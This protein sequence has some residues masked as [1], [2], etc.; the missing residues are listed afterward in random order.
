M[1]QAIHA[2]CM[3]LQ[4]GHRPLAFCKSSSPT[5]EYQENICENMIYQQ[6]STINHQTST[7]FS[8]FRYFWPLTI[9]PTDVIGCLF[10]GPLGSHRRVAVLDALPHDDWGRSHWLG[11]LCL[12]L[13]ETLGRV[14]H[15]KR[16]QNV[17][18]A[19]MLMFKI[20]LWHLWCLN[21]LKWLLEYLWNMNMS[22]DIPTNML[23]WE[24]SHGI[25]NIIY[26]YIWIS[27]V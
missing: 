18:W 7:M 24:Y 10:V 2:I 19:S 25:W 11:S 17:S 16:W 8:I 26:I 22:L 23:W 9:S 27:I 21:V 15:R 20:N 6:Y 4:V 12:H 1:P 5:W 3:E 13:P 14:D